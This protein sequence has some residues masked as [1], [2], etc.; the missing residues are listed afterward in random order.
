MV[1]NKIDKIVLMKRASVED[2]IHDV[3]KNFSIN[4]VKIDAPTGF[5]GVF[6]VST[7]D[8]TGLAELKSFIRQRASRL[9]LKKYDH[10]DNYRDLPIIGQEKAPKKKN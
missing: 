5:F 9:D 4:Q 2:K 8:S 10:R 7:K 3:L 1:L 6:E